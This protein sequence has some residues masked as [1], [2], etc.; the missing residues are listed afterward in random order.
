MGQSVE[1][2]EVKAW[3][4]KTWFAIVIDWKVEVLWIK[5]I[6]KI[7]VVS[8][9]RQR[10]SIFWTKPSEPIFLFKILPF[11]IDIFLFTEWTLIRTKQL[12]KT[13]NVLIFSIVQTVTPCFPKLHLQ[14]IH[15]FELWTGLAVKY[16]QFSTNE[17]R[18]WSITLINCKFLHENKPLDDKWLN[19]YSMNL[20]F[21]FLGFRGYISDHVY[22]WY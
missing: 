13:T 3:P 14:L 2:N 17:S 4:T 12:N 8:A 19:S 18:Q 1:W 22:N 7:S 16:I 21:H 11:V 10:L 5:Q 6:K 15:Y 9:T 20:K